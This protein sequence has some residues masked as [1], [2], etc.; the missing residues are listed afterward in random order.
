MTVR[1]TDDHLAISECYR[2][3]PHWE[4]VMLGPVPFGC[5]PNER[6]QLA[7]QV[8]FSASLEDAT[9]DAWA[10]ARSVC[11]QFNYPFD[12]SEWDLV[13]MRLVNAN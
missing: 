13:Y 10:Y 2:L 6:T 3:A 11:A 9:A 12:D 5:P 7:I 1:I 4:G 8:L